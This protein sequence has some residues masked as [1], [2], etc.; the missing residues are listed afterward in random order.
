MTAAARS[1]PPGRRPAEVFIG[2]RS[3]PRS[4]GTEVGGFDDHHAVDGSPDG[5]GDLVGGRRPSVDVYHRRASTLHRG[6]TTC[7]KIQTELDNNSQSILGYIV[8]W[9]G[10]GVGCSTVPDIHD[11]VAS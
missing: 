6:M 7:T 9:V 3:G 8:R 10:L 2:G 11:V 4:E 5:E 1:R